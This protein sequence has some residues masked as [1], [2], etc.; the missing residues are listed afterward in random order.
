MAM[1]VSSAQT[2]PVDQPNSTN[3]S[4]TI[5]GQTWRGGSYNITVF[6]AVNGISLVLS[7]LAITA[8]MVGRWKNTKL[9][10]RTS[11]KI[12][13][14]LY[15]L[16]IVTFSAFNGHKWMRSFWVL[17]LSSFFIA[18]VSC[19]LFWT[20][21]VIYTE[22]M[23]GC[24]FADEGVFFP[25]Y[26]TTAL[27]VL[28]IINFIL[29]IAI[30]ARLRSHLKAMKNRNSD[31]PSY[32]KS[33]NMSQGEP[34]LSDFDD[35]PIGPSLKGDSQLM[36]DEPE[37]LRNDDSTQ[38]HA[39]GSSVDKS[40]EISAPP[41]QT[42]DSLISVV[43]K[44]NL[45]LFIPLI[46]ELAIC[47]ADTLNTYNSIASIIQGILQSSKGIVT[48]IVLWQDPAIQVAVKQTFVN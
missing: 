19:G 44:V 16:I 2:L 42:S 40:Q 36:A 47:V 7:M 3:L 5:T 18:A 43:M 30:F 25:G 24:W 31:I 9:F 22:F 33:P 21:P 46:T 11:L 4:T 14:S 32:L 45:Y 28:S 13:L 8:F 6:T 12:V 37:A 38:A 17:F 23:Y 1:Q 27:F 48:F 20:T 15:Q 10:D 35:C 34:G 26:A 29:A 41:P 39:N